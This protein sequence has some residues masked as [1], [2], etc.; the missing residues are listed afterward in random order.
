MRI[1]I[2]E[3]TSK[4]QFDASILGYTK[5]IDYCVCP[6]LPAANGTPEFGR[7]DSGAGII[8][9]PTDPGG[10][11]PGGCDP[12]LPIDGPWEGCAGDAELAPV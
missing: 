5:K 2:H 4:M 8:L 1:I 12:M 9:P 11:V 3:N 7:R 6:A 10:T